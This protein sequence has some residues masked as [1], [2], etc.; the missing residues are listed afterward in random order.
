MLRRLRIPRVPLVARPAVGGRRS[1]HSLPA[2]P[3]DF[4]EG[5]PGLL[6]ADGHEMA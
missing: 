6:S 1:L 5:V 3:H 4:K 2:L